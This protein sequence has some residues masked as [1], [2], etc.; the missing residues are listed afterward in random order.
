[1]EITR[2]SSEGKLIIPQAMLDA[3]RWERGQELIVI[4][5]GDGILIKPKKPFVET[6]LADVAGC[7]KYLGKPKSI[8]DLEEAIRLGVQ[9]Q[10]HDIG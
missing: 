1:M 10:W 7:L 3:H 2:L 9:E 6:T 4:D 5:M 8:Q